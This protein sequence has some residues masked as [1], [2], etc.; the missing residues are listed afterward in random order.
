MGIVD[1]LKKDA[2]GNRTVV[3]TSEAAE[4]SKIFNRTFYLPRDIEE[5]TKFIHSVMTRG[6]EDAER[7]GLHAS[8]LIVS[9]NKFCLRQQVLAL[10]FKQLQGE[11]V[12]ID[13]KRIFEE[14]NAVHEKLQRLFIRAGYSK[15]DDLDITRF[16]AAF[17]VSF[18]PDI[19]CTIPEFFEGKMIGEIKS[20]NTFQ[21]Q[22]M[23][24]HPSAS[25]QLL[26]YMYLC[27]Q[28]EKRKGTWNGVDYTKG[29][30]LCEDKN[31]QML[32]FEVYDYDRELVQSYIDR[33]RAVK[34]AYKD[35]KHT[36]NMVAR[37]KDA[38]SITCKRCSNCNLQVACYSP[39]K[40]EL[41]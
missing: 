7:K 25:H 9:D 1:E 30:V 5:E 12:N 14:G 2:I 35:F 21:F 39:S 24:K 6:Q 22:R 8:A 18:T 41:L 29:F 33:C 16:N 34:D 10:L 19:I 11:Q 36:G 27:I 4:L 32:K 40:A 20:V 26:F 13:L 31:T 15:Y 3:Q 37:P 28:E 17:R 38:T 23:N